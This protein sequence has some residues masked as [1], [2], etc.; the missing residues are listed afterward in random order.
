M[1]PIVPPTE[2][3]DT[4]VSQPHITT[5]S[6][7]K[8]SLMYATMITTL[9]SWCVL[10][11]ESHSDN[12][13]SPDALHKSGTTSHPVITDDEIKSVIERLEADKNIYPL[14]EINPLLQ[15][16]LDTIC[17][18]IQNDLIAGRIW[19]SLPKVKIALSS[20][21]WKIFGDIPEEDIQIGLVPVTKDGNWSI[22][23]K[24]SARLWGRTYT[25]SLMIPTENYMATGSAR[26]LDDWELATM[27]SQSMKDEFL[28]HIRHKLEA[29]LSIQTI[30]D[31]SIPEILEYMRPLLLD[32]EEWFRA[33]GHPLSGP[34]TIPPIGDKDLIDVIITTKSPE[35]ELKFTF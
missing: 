17:T 28:L 24:L 15:K 10:P 1:Q 30:S 4:W 11:K 16:E 22:F 5:P 34:V 6:G 32:E 20:A 18:Q 3:V 2:W 7:L 19:C 8:K 26:P 14:T 9:L 29:A 33:I 21:L 31:D 27:I 13:S 35:W 23:A 25:S 12:I